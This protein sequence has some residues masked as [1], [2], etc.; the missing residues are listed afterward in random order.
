M[1]NG[2]ARV[3]VGDVVHKGDLLV[4]GIMEGQY[5]GIR[6]VHAEAT[7]YGKIYYE[8]EKTE[9]YMQYEKKETGR[10]EVKNQ[11]VI[12]KLKINLFKGVSNFEN[13]DK[14]NS[15]K[16]IKIFSN[17]YLP[18]EFIKS[19]YY[20]IENQKIEYAQEELIEKIKNELEEEMELEFEISNF[21]K[22]NIDEKVE[23]NTFEEGI[24]LK[25]IYEIQKEIG[26]KAVEE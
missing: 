17:F 14:I 20:E 12:N 23:V 11:I 26:V 19:T 3:N 1:Q 4:E 9:N 15:S 2:T 8:K 24:T 18:I 25:L 6:N 21:D 7:V 10:K 5:T 22:N 13:Y 16:K